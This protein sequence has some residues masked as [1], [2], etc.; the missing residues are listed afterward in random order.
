MKCLRSL[1]LSPPESRTTWLPTK[2]L[3]RNNRPT[4][5]RAPGGQ[6]QGGAT[7]AMRGHRRGA[8]TQ[9]MPTRRRAPP[10]CGPLA[11]LL[12]PYILPGMLVAPALP[13]GLGAAAKCTCYSLT[14]PKRA[15]NSLRP[16]LSFETASGEPPGAKRRAFFSK[17]LELSCHESV[18][19]ADMAA[20]ES[21]P[22]WNIVM[23]KDLCRPV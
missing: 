9:Q 8:P 11:A 1:C 17:L 5:A 16:L 14:G 21:R 4:L 6:M 22:T 10:G 12:A 23:R 18:R 19:F 20:L 2:G 15:R 7:Q 13:A 3:S